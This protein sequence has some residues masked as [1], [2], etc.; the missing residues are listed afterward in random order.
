MSHEQIAVALVGARRFSSG[1]LLV[2]MPLIMERILQIRDLCSATNNAWA[3]LIEVVREERYESVGDVPGQ[4]PT[5]ERT[6][7]APSAHGGAFG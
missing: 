5:I 2:A 4:R 1:R 3:W 7:P 6:P